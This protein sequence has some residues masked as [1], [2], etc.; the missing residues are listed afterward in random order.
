[1]PSKGFGSEKPRSD[2]Q[3]IATKFFNESPRFRFRT[4]EEVAHDNRKQE[5]ENRRTF[6]QNS[7]HLLMR[8]P[9]EGLL[10]RE[11]LMEFDPQ[12]EFNLT[13]HGRDA[14]GNKL[15]HFV[16]GKGYWTVHVGQTDGTKSKAF[17]WQI[18]A[19]VTSGISHVPRVI[20]EMIIKE[21]NLETYNEWK[22]RQL[23][24]LTSLKWCLN[25]ACQFL[26]KKSGFGASYLTSDSSQRLVESLGIFTSRGWAF[27]TSDYRADLTQ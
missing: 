13:H 1:M 21:T 18:N 16:W 7:I 14:A 2:P 3:D 4:P 23:R 15:T 27:L 8:N 17:D 19:T 6:Q 5:D 20:R 26:G 24:D 12:D 22:E 10:T 9:E 11:L 25:K